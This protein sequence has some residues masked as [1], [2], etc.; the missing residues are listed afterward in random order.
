MEDGCEL[1]VKHEGP[2]RLFNECAGFGYYL[3]RGVCVRVKFDG[4]TDDSMNERDVLHSKQSP[5]SDDS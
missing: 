4:K 5:R 3:K 1:G 2:T